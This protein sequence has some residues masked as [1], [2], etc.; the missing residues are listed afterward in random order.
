MII[1]LGRGLVLGLVRSR[2]WRGIVITM[3]N[4]VVIL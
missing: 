1:V 4:M 2:I 3:A